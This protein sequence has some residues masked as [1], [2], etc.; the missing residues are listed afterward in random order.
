MTDSKDM[1]ECFNKKI[2]EFARDLTS[3]YPSDADIL[4]FKTS[5][6]CMMVV[7][8]RKPE[9]MYHAFVATPYGDW[10]LAK[11]ETFFLKSKEIEQAV[12]SHSEF[13][14]LTQGLLTK[15]REYWSQM[16]ADD[17]TAVW[18]YFKVL[19]LLSRKLHA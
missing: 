19:T 1:L 3:L 10:L 17:K 7:D 2:T 4:S 12:D 6:A 15:L 16:S 13:P 18:N 14:E 11:D 8:T 9:K 5:L